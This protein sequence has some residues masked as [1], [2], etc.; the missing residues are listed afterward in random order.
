MHSLVARP[1]NIDEVEIFFEDDE[2]AALVADVATS[3]MGS[4]LEEATGRI[5]EIYV[6]VPDGNGGLHLA[7]GGVFS[8]YEFPWDAADR[9]TDEAWREMLATGLAP[10]QPEWTGSYVAE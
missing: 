2:E 1:T 6:A 3:P 7:K 10:D 8:Y 5:Y 9:L 4:V